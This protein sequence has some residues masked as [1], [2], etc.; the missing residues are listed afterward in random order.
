M[1]KVPLPRGGAAPIRS[2]ADDGRPGS[3][4]GEDR[5]NTG[6]PQRPGL[7]TSRGE[8]LAGKAVMS[9]QAESTQSADGSWMLWATIGLAAIW[10]CVLL[11]S[12]FSPDLVSGSEQEHLPLAAF[13]AW[14][15]GLIATGGF[16]WG[17][18][19]L[20]GTVE[21]QP[22]WIGLG[23]AVVVIWVIATALSLWLPV[24]ETGSD[25][26]RLPVG[27]LIAPLGAAAL[28]AIASVVA[29]LFS[30]RPQPL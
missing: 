14:L 5:R 8:T 20:R 7:L 16:L 12:V 2:P 11:I 6:C 23:T 24:Q 29:G 30:Q 25:P 18:A 13:F 26:T 17:M 15:W 10:I 19:K 27:A 21:R 9:E 1:W 22:I 3:S 4:E 28:T